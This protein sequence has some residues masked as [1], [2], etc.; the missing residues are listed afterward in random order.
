MNVDEKCNYKINL[1]I[2][3]LKC[4][5]FLFFWESCKN[6]THKHTTIYLMAEFLKFVGPIGPRGQK[7]MRS[8]N[9]V[10]TDKISRIQC[11]CKFRVD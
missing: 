6:D 5:D 4:I 8:A 1:N 2:P 9:N 11:G 10:K 7:I 3:F